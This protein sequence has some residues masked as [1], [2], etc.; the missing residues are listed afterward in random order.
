MPYRFCRTLR[1]VLPL[2]GLAGALAVPAAAQT[3]SYTTI[4]SADL[5]TPDLSAMPPPARDQSEAS[6][7]T[8]AGVVIGYA[9]IGPEVFSP[10]GNYSPG[11]GY[12]YDTHSGAST[13]VNYQAAN[14]GPAFQ[15]VSGDG[16]QVLGF[17]NPG[18]NGAANYFT[19]SGGHISALPDPFVLTG[20][21]PSSPY[22]SAEYAGINS[23]GTTVETLSPLRIAPRVFSAVRTGR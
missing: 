20:T 3:Y 17:Y 11:V 1:A 23:S 21:D 4:T 12:E 13:L 10:N 16:S 14:A 5:G 15:A 19:D 6:G 8:N 22:A 18:G 9:P 2:I 7:I